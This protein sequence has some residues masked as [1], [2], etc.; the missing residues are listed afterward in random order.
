MKLF[1]SKLRK[2]LEAKRISLLKERLKIQDEKAKINLLL[3]QKE[4]CALFVKD[5]DIRLKINLIDELLQ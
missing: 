5:G 4:Y 2:R 3:S 1:K